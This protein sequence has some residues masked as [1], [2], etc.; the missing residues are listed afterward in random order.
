MRVTKSEFKRL[1][2]EKEKLESRIK[3]SHEAQ[4]AAFKLHE[5]ALEELRVHYA[6]EQRLR[7]QMDL[8]EK[9]AEEAIAMESRELEELE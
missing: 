1:A 2:A 8:L 9:R 4:D 7:L 5:K 6:C 3:E